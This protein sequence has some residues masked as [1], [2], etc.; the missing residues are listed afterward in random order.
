MNTLLAGF[1]DIRILLAL[2]AALL[3][4]GAWYSGAAA[5]FDTGP[6]M[7]MR[8]QSGGQEASNCCSMHGA[9]HGNGPART[10]GTVDEAVADDLNLGAQTREWLEGTR[11]FE[12][13]EDRTGE[14]E[15]VVKVGAGN[16]LTYAPEAVRVDPG[17]TIRWVWTGNGGSHDVAFVNTDVSA[18][19]RGEQ[20]AEYTY[21]FTEPGEYRYECTP[22]ASVGM[23]GMVIVEE[24]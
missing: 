13:I 22:H 20:G 6:H 5:P 8:G 1:S 24:S 18:S 14:R 17:T 2:G 9:M 19:L 23:R 3:I 11:G 12:T 16:G 10:N 7:G 15:V 21:T 4:G